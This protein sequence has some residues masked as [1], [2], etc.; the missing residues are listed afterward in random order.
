MKGRYNKNIIIKEKEMKILENKFFQF[1]VFFLLLSLIVYLLASIDA[2]SKTAEPQTITVTGTGEVY[3]SPD[4]GMVNVSVINEGKD[5]G[6]VTNENNETMN[7][8]ISFLKGK[9]IEGKDIKTTVYN[10]NPR[11][12]YNSETG[13]RTFTGYEITQTVNVKIR[14]LTKVG[15]IISGATEMKA[16]EISSLSFIVDDDEAV[17]EQAKE[18][19]IKDAKEK[20]QKLGKALGVNL[21]KIVGFYESS[22]P[23]YDNYY[24]VG[25]AESM[26]ASSSITPPT[27]E[28]GQNKITSNVSITYAIR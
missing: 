17:K 13:K 15:E 9:G 7:G 12:E 8:I 21:D 1:L 26:K 16:D 18:L 6:T 25:G 2:K 20:A 3:V 24:G 5:I 19:A 28:T 23:I 27:I 10:I 4:V 11:Y 14:D 22:Y